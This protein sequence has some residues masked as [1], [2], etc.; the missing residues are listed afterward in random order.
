[1]RMNMSGF[2]PDLLLPR[3]SKAEKNLSGWTTKWGG[4]VKGRIRSPRILSG[5]A[6]TREKIT[7]FFQE[8]EKISNHLKH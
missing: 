4:G 8:K 6:A 5:G 2:K 7:F 3:I 1:M